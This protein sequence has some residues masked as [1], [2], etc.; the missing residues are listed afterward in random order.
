MHS[1]NV[2]QMSKTCKTKRQTQKGVQD[3]FNKIV[4]ESEQSVDQADDRQHYPWHH[5]AWFSQ[6][7]YSQSKVYSLIF[8][9]YLPSSVDEEGPNNHMANADDQKDPTIT[10][11]GTN[12]S[13]SHPIKCKLTPSEDRNPSFISIGAVS[14]IVNISTVS[15]SAVTLIF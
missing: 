10:V 6:R 11:P 15:R 2:C 7:N 4:N 3:A 12:L 9:S 5:E 1:C 8:G 13:N 14:L